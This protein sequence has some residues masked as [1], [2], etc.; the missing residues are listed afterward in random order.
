MSNHNYEK[1]EI[2]AFSG[3][4]KEGTHCVAVGRIVVVGGW[5][6]AKCVIVAGLGQCVVFIGPHLPY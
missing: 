1:K 4:E 2:A 3:W 5:G 6:V